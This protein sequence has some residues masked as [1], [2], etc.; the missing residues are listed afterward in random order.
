MI[1]VYDD[2]NIKIHL[3]EV[4]HDCKLWVNG[5][6]MEK[7]IKVSIVYEIDKVTVVTM[8]SLGVV[9]YLDRTFKGSY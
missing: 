5:K 9:T 2:G 7:L 3:Y 6:L 1:G 8:D 4:G